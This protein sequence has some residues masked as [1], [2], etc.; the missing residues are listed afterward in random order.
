M[1]STDPRLDA[2]ITKSADFAKPILKHLRKIVHAG[3]PEVEETMK[4]S[5]PFF[6]HNGILCNMAAFKNHCSFGF[7]K[8]ALIFPKG[9]APGNKQ[10]EGMGQFGRITAVSDL[11]KDKV[12]IGF[13][14]EA[15]RL[16]ET[17]TRPP[18]EPKP[19]ERK[20]LIVPAELVSVLNRAWSTATAFSV[21]GSRIPPAA[22]SDTRGSALS[23]LSNRIGAGLT[24]DDGR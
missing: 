11:P 14:K 7:W 10:D 20:E 22:T 23:A 8:R 6:M 1:G 21:S 16:N 24:V 4:W 5:S 12:L 2:Y 19:K 9:R 15:V 17:G 18:A 13:I 3:C